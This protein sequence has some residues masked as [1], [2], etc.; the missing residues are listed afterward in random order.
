MRDDALSREPEPVT[1]PA[2]AAGQGPAPSAPGLGG[3]PRRRRRRRVGLGVPS[4]LRR[5]QA[6]AGSRGARAR[7]GQAPPTVDLALQPPTG[8]SPAE[9]PP[10]A[11]PAGPRVPAPLGLAALAAAAPAEE[12]HDTTRTSMTCPQ[13]SRRGRPAPASARPWTTTRTA[14]SAAARPTPLRS[15]RT[16]LTSA[17]SRRDPTPSREAQS[18]PSSAEPPTEL[19]CRSRRLSPSPSSSQSRRQRRAEH[20]RRAEL[21][22]EPTPLAEPE[23]REAV[24]PV[25]VIEIERHAARLGCRR[26]HRCRLRWRRRHGRLVARDGDLDL[27]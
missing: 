5:D 6:G 11:L 24:E 3:Q 8:R 7:R 25:D 23:R 12:R 26:R 1:P 19:E 4:A 14:P 2:D 15:R 16:S 17:R 22:V 20:R 27:G 13:A 10:R 9:G 18:R 21:L